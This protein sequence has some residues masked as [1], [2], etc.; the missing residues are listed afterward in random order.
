MSIKITKHKIIRFTTF[1]KVNGRTIDSYIFQ[2]L[3]T[4]CDL[5]FCKKKY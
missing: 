2:Y 5:K 4:V 1:C 3:G